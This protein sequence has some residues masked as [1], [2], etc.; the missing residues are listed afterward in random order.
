VGYQVGIGPGFFKGIAQ[1]RQPLRVQLARGEQAVLVGLLRKTLDE[2]VVPGPDGRRESQG[3]EREG[4][5]QVTKE[6]ALA[7]RSLAYLCQ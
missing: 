2:A 5:E 4:P 6:V 7:G 3:T 1:H